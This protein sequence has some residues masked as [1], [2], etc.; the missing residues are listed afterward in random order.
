VESNAWRKE[1]SGVALTHNNFSAVAYFYPS[2]TSEFFLKGGLGMASISVGFAGISAAETDGGSVLG[3]GVD[4]PVG[5][6]WSI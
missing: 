1:V 2:A 6:N 3:L 4:I 5:E